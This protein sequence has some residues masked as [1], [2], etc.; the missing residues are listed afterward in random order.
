MNM[1]MSENANLNDWYRRASI[2]PWSIFRKTEYNK[3]F[4]KYHKTIVDREKLKD[5]ILDVTSAEAFLFRT[6]VRSSL[7]P[8]F[9][10]VTIGPNLP[11]GTDISEL[12]E[13][14]NGSLDKITGSLETLDGKM[15][16]GVCNRDIYGTT[17][18]VGFFELKFQLTIGLV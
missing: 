1:N 18:P 5:Y 2:N 16:Q 15:I 14:L 7:M 13:S 3:G 8:L 11:S 10:A 17:A 6:E 9:L 4:K 12:H